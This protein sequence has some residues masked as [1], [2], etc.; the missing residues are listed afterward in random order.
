M[1]QIADEI[2]SK[3]S[4]EIEISL[5]MIYPLIKLYI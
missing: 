1:R 4:T 3:I 5:I 2:I